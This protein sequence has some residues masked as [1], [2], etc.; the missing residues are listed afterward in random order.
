MSL[1]ISPNAPLS[2]PTSDRRAD[3]VANTRRPLRPSHL[4]PVRRRVNPAVTAGLFQIGD[5]V[6]LLA[7]M[8]YA[9]RKLGWPAI[10]GASIAVA[11]ALV[12]GACGVYGFPRGER[13]RAHLA[14]VV[15]AAGASLGAFTGL[16][17][18]A[19]GA[20]DAA[21][22]TVLGASALGVALLHAGW[23]RL[24]QSWRRNGLVTPNI[25][26]VGATPTAR[27][28]I[29]TLMDAGGVNIIGIFD[30]RASRSP[31]GIL[32]IPVLGGLEDL[33]A[34]HTLPAVDLVVVTVPARAQARIAQLLERLSHAP[35]EIML[36]LDQ[37][38]SG[39]TER[40]GHL[41][42]RRL[43]GH[44]SNG[45]RAVS[46]RA[47]DLVLVGLAT[48][49]LAPVM[50]AIAAAV[51]LDSPGPIFFRQRRHGFNNEQFLV[52]KFRSMRADAADA[53]ASLQVQADDARVTRVG[54]FIRRTSLDELP[55]MFNV[56]AGEMS[57]VGPRPHAVGMKSAGQDAARLVD[58]YA[59]RHRLKPGLTGWAVV[60]G[61]RG[62]VDDAPSLKRRLQLDM[63]YIERQS[64]WFDLW[65]MWR[66]LP[67]V[68][69]DTSA[70]R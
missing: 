63:D 46:K 9:S 21:T 52:W 33:V 53:T 47:Q 62:P 42:L 41:A 50:L 29:S 14:L 37:D 23:W 1:V 54:R 11:C 5:T 20:V 25:V 38:K 19:A 13:L 2:G 12:L 39:A 51:K 56:L 22:V 68:L 10:D 60:C 45:W 49:L 34:H 70:P 30:D 65:V 16:I 40:L 6:A 64:F 8:A 61:S 7:A 55:Q 48:I 35:N 18:G 15:V 66:T 24:F 36:A 43:E 69:G 57:L 59:H 3:G 26:I 44:R 28:L 4:V 27:A 32:G 31:D 67:L 17:I 58:C